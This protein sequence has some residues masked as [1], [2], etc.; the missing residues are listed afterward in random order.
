VGSRNI[1]LRSVLASH[2][3]VCTGS[4]QTP[5]SSELP[6]SPLE[7]SVTRHAGYGVG[8]GSIPAPL[9]RGI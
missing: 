6:I 9:G 5:V 4:I 8:S 7:C 2:C 3:V 1:R